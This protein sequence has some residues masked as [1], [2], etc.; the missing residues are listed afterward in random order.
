LK[1]AKREHTSNKYF[2]ENYVCC[3]VVVMFR[4]GVLRKIFGSK[5]KGV[6]GDGGNH[7]MRNF[8]MSAV[9]QIS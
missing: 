9:Q 1:K 8:V 5:W 6:R 3:G 7:I 4:E 2:I